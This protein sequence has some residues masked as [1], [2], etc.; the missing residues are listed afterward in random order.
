MFHNVIVG[1]DE[2]RAGRAGIAVAKNLPSRDGNV[3]QDT[4][5]EWA[6]VAKSGR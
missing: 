5:A 4:Y 3:T 2:H 1:V 6:A